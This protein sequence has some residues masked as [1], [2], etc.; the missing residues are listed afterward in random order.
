[1]ERGFF[2][3]QKLRNLTSKP[4][5]VTIRDE[6]GTPPLRL[7]AVGHNGVGRRLRRK[8]ASHNGPN[9]R[10]LSPDRRAN[11]TVH[12]GPAC[13]GAHRCAYGGA[14]RSP[15]YRPNCRTHLAAHGHPRS[16]ADRT[17]RRPR[18]PPLPSR[19]PR[20]L[21]SR[22]LSRAPTEIRSNLTPRHNAWWS[23][24]ARR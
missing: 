5:E 15:D 23:T 21:G 11:P 3:A 17:T 9:E 1:M 7:G 6:K 24:T 16:S 2:F 19:R 4:K 20:R 18:P 13:S 14:N 8:R 10:T 22:W 12:L